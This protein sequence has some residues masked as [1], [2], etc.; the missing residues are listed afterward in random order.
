M[1]TYLHLFSLLLVTLFLATSCDPV[2]PE[3]SCDDLVGTYEGT[4]TG[5]FSGELTLRVVAKPTQGYAEVSGTWSGTDPVTGIVYTGK[6]NTIQ[7]DCD[8]GRLDYEYGLNLSGPMDVLCPS[9]ESW[10]YE[11][12]ATLGRFEGTIGGNS[13]SGSWRADSGAANTVGV[14]GSGTWTVSKN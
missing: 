12:G 13:A 7:M 5:S 6:I 4:F 3:N 11:T 9:S 8:N 14:T 1:K 2:D 10:C